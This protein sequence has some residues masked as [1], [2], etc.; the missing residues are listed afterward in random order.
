MVMQIGLLLFLAGNL[1]F[2]ACWAF[3]STRRETLSNSNGEPGAQAA[4]INRPGR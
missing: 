2:V 3:V 4:G 1:I